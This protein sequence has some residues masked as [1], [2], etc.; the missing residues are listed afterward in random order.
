MR[1]D[2]TESDLSL[3]SGRKR[4]VLGSWVK[5]T[6]FQPAVVGKKL[7]FQRGLIYMFYLIHKILVGEYLYIIHF[8]CFRVCTLLHLFS[9]NFDTYNHCC[10]NKCVARAGR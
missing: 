3:S 7:T 5:K 9:L 1:V 10:S 2:A 4:P 6:N 8:Q